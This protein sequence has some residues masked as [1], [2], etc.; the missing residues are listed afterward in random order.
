MRFDL[1]DPAQF[2]TPSTECLFLFR[3]GGV[4]VIDLRDPT[5]GV[6]EDLRHGSPVNAQ[7]PHLR[8]DRSP[9]VVEAPSLNA[10][11]LVQKKLGLAKPRHRLVA[12]RARANDVLAGFGRGAEDFDGEGR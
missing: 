6:V 7:L 3:L 12:A 10:R 8:G 11:M 9:D 1:N 2:L 4:S 5:L